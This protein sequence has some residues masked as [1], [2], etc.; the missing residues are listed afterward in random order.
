M[1]VGMNNCVKLRLVGLPQ[2][3]QLAIGGAGPFKKSKKKKL[4]RPQLG[5][6]L[7]CSVINCS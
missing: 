2:P 4:D 1:T 6:A 5:L 7:K 3:I